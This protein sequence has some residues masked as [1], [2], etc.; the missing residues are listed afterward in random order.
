MCE[1]LLK[2]SNLGATRVHLI[3]Y[4]YRFRGLP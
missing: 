2:V 1:S 4:S 3:V